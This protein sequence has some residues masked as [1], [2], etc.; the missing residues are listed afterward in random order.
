LILGLQPVREA[1]RVHGARL[2]K[3]VVQSNDSPRL[4]A[5]A[6]F[7]SDQGVA[8]ERVQKRQLDKLSQGGMH[9]GA[10]AWAPNLELRDFSVLL[11]RPQLL[12]IALDGIQDPQN[13]GAVVR[14]AVA[15]GNVPVV[16]GEHASAPLTPATFRASAGAVEHAELYKVK[17]LH[18][19]LSEAA[20][21]GAQV[22]GLDAQAPTPLHQ[23][24]LLVPTL[25]VIGSEDKGMKRAV[26]RTC[27]TLAHLVAPGRVE[28][29]NAS[30]A[31]GS[32]LYEALVQRIKSA[33]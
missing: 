29:L 23:V 5:L 17:S 27:T 13:F 8:V 19:A 9:Q 16:W 31:A 15:M 1:L 33:T 4:E 10:I 32:A 28:S 12:A 18:G 20:S 26:R 22:V 7:A 21:L 30:V 25:L 14:S 24:D 11:Q 2:T 6:R 3:L